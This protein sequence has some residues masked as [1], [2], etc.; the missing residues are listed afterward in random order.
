MAARSRARSLGVI[1]M[2]ELIKALSKSSLSKSW[3]KGAI[4]GAVTIV[5][6]G[7]KNGYSTAE[8]AFNL[9]QAEHETASWMQPIREGCRLWGP[10]G[11]D[12]QAVRAIRSAINKGLIKSNYL[13]VT[14]GVTHYGRGLIQITW[15]DNY[16][17]FEK[18]LKQPLVSKPDL[19]L[20]WDVALY[21]LY[22]GINKGLFR[23][24]KFSDYIAAGTEPT[25]G[26]YASARNIINGDAKTYGASLGRRAMQFYA[27]LKPLEAKLKANATK[28]PGFLSSVIK[29]IKGV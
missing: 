9:A 12:A 10:A 21:I 16:L 14:N 19:A 25:Q 1:S 4:E 22:E 17:K 24:A 5:E 13:A 11:T 7:Y 8:I 27:I 6:Y 18:L 29:V 3:K 26:K 28:S 20:N 2:E 23:K 15:K